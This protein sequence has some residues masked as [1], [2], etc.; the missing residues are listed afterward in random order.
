M[1]ILT[2]LN[3]TRN[4]WITEKSHALHS[5]VFILL[6]RRIQVAGRQTGTIVCSAVSVLLQF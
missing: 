6:I 2:I 5:I 3:S 1:E 4:V